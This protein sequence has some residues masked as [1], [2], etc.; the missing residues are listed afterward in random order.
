[1]FCKALEGLLEGMKK[2]EKDQITPG[3][4]EVTGSNP[5]FSTKKN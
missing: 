2:D 1:L 3:R 5:V 4:Q